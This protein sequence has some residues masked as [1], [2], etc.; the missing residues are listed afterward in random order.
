MLYSEF[1]S[2]KFQI[3][4]DFYPQTVTK[5]KRASCEKLKTYRAGNDCAQRFTNQNTHTHTHTHTHT[6]THRDLCL[7]IL[8]HRLQAP[9]SRHRLDHLAQLIHASRQL[10]ALILCPHAWLCER[11]TCVEFAIETFSH[12]KHVYTYLIFRIYLCAH[13][14]VYTCTLIPKFLMFSRNV[15]ASWL[16]CAIACKFSFSLCTYSLPCASC[17]LNLASSCCVV[18]C[19]AWRLRSNSDCAC[20]EVCMHMCV[21]VCTYVCACMYVCMYE[22]MPCMSC[23]SVCCVYIFVCTWLYIHIY[24]YAEVSATDS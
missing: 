18:S 21:C 8:Q 5:S 2:T 10:F 12:S 17:R 22:C 9:V 23:M 16:P 1:R 11:H 7:G 4:N 3:H 19:R 14:H 24:T 13:T 15:A 6:R 20:K